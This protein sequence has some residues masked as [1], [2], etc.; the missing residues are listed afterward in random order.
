MERC[1]GQV[2]MP[3]PIQRRNSQAQPATLPLRRAFR[4]CL[5]I[6]A[7]TLVVGCNATVIRPERDTYVETDSPQNFSVGIAKASAR[8]GF[9]YGTLPEGQEQKLYYVPAGKGTIYEQ[10]I[11]AAVPDETL[12][13]SHIANFTTGTDLLLARGKTEQVA[14]LES[15]VTTL[16]TSLPQVEVEAKVVEVFVSDGL[17][18]GATTTFTE[19]DANPK[20]FFDTTTSRFNTNSFIESLTAGSP[21]GFQGGLINFG[22]IHDELIMDAVLEGIASSENT[23][24][25]A[26]PI[27]RVLSGYTGTVI[28]GERTPVQTARVVNNVVTVDTKF[29]QT[30]IKLIVTPSAIGDDDVQM[31]VVPEVSVVTGFTAPGSTGIQSPIIS[32]RN[33]DTTVMVKS[34]HTLVM[35]G[36]TSK[37][38]VEVESRVP[39]LGSIPLLRYFFRSIRKETATTRLYFFITPRI[40]NDEGQYGGNVLYPPEGG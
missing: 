20:T 19:E 12:T 16:E 27:L 15:F 17:E 36:L 21:A 33:A 25:I 1:S 40:T 14:T 10:L 6:A 35:G 7:T 4:L 39:I 18:I 13:L 24:I 9:S 22:T 38:I 26:T 11:R 37:Q 30:G 3:N 32:T 34:G 31:H 28:T 23:E 2:G 8:R 5:A 29:E